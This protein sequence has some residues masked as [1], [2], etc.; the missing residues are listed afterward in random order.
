MRSSETEELQRALRETVR[1]LEAM[2]RELTHLLAPGQ[3]RPVPVQEAR[4]I[5]AAA[6]HTLAQVG[7]R[8]D[9]ELPMPPPE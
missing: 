6:A 4:R 2:T 1:A 5:L 7:Q 9:D 3:A 8:I